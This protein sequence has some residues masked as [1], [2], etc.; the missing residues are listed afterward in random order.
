M[1]ELSAADPSQ[2]ARVRAQLTMDG[3]LGGF[4]VWEEGEELLGVRGGRLILTVS[5]CPPFELDALPA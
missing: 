3:A 5:R 1:R 2:V 4:R